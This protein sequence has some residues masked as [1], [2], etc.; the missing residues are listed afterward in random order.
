MQTSV[1]ILFISILFLSFKSQ[2]QTKIYLVPGQGS[3]YRIFS[4]IKFP[5]KYKICHINYVIPNKEESLRAY[6]KRLSTQI[7]KDE[8]F[9]IIGVSLG[10]M[11]ATEIAEIRAPEKVIIISS[12]KNSNELPK[13]YNFQK[14][15]PV[16]KL[17]GAKL[18]KRGAR[19]LQ[20]IVEPDRNRE[21][22]T[23]K[24]MLDAKDPEF[25][26]R[27]IAMIINWEKESNSKE[28]IHIHGDN[29]KTVPIKNVEYDYLVKNGSH[30]MALTEA[31]KISAILQQILDE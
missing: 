20:P 2:G 30:M 11:I 14:R 25:L 26:K 28:I 13:R 22:E 23:F 16:Y 31:G 4:K 9:I 3:D 8:K 19:V 15:I 7:P 18:S 24:S 21:K 29:D 6:A 27:T 1:K 17:V 12:A 10:G 5:P